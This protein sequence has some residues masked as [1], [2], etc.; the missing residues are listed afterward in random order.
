MDRENSE[1]LIYSKGKPL[2]FIDRA[3]L[4]TRRKI[5]SILAK[6]VDL[7]DLDSI[8]DVGAT[9]DQTCL[10][11]NYFENQYPRKER[12]TALSN[13]QAK[14]LEDVFQGLRF[15]QGDGCHLPFADASFDLVFSSAVWE[16]VGSREQQLLFLQECLRVTRRYVFITTPNRWHP[17]ELHTG[18]PF[19]HWL[20]PSLCRSFQ[21]WLSYGKMTAEGK[22]NLL[23]KNDIKRMMCRINAPDYA[24]HAAF[25][26]G[27]PSNLLLLIDKK[28]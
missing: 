20:P 10:S 15:V 22:L 26:L 14:W 24:L 28:S 4:R 7:D 9:A 1:E 18:L 3:T 16:H 19:V 27:A 11:S 21:K 13:Q 23:S 17:L 6:L 12:I 2:S 25:F 5:Y 8:L